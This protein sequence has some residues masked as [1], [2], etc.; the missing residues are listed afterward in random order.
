MRNCNAAPNA[1]RTEALALQQRFENLAGDEL[2]QLSCYFGQ[3]QQSLLLIFRLERGD[4][5]LRRYQI[6]EIHGL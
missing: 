1:R 6:T 2:G 3:F 5:T 4:D